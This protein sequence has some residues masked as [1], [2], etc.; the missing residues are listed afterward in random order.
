MLLQRFDL[1]TD[2]GLG[3]RKF[4]RCRGKTQEPASCLESPQSCTRRQMAWPNDSAI[5]IIISKVADTFVLGRRN[6]FSLGF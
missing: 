5:R 4:T 3:D 2:R 6:L 1:M